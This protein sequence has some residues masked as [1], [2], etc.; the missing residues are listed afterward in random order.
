[1]KIKNIII[2]LLAVTLSLCLAAPP[3]WAGN[4]QR[5]RWEGVAIGIGASVLG[6]ALFSNYFHRQAAPEVVY[7]HPSPRRHKPY[8]HRK[9]RAYWEIRKEWVPPTYER[10]WNPG[11]YNRRG[12]WVEGR[13]MEIEKEPGYWIEKRVRVSKHRRH[14]RHDYD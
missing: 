11:H 1:M 6:H 10:V 4:V 2:I 14:R 7:R 13:W 3:A 8:Y 12:H 5:N 9:A